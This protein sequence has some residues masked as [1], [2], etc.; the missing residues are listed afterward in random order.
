VLDW[1]RVAVANNHLLFPS[2]GVLQNGWGVMVFTLVGKDYYPTAAYAIKRQNADDFGPVRIAELGKAPWDGFT[3]Y[4]PF[5]GQNRPRWGDYHMAVSDGSSIWGTVEYIESNC[6][7][8]EWYASN[9]ACPD[10]SRTS[11]SNWGTRN[12]QIVP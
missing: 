1:G 10:N 7:Y 11:L 5:T 4:P 2:W 3:G 9:F 12:F 8:A 6:T